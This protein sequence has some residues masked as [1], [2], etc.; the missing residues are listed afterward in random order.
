ML[1]SINTTEQPLG[2]NGDSASC[3]RGRFD[4]QPEVEAEPLTCSNCSKVDESAKAAVPAA[5]KQDR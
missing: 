2:A 5:E 4:L 3:R 1:I